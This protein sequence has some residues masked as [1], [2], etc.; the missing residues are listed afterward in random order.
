M[1]SNQHYQAGKYHQQPGDISIETKPEMTQI[2]WGDKNFK[3]AIINMFHMFK[4]IEES[5]I[6][7]NGEVEDIKK[8]SCDI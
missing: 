6:I 4:K 5:M 3:T 8:T 1:A 7:L 2:K